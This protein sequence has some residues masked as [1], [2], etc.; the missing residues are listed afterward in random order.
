MG[1]LEFPLNTSTLITRQLKVLGSNGG[2]QE[3]I[4]N[5]LELISKG[6]LTID[7]QL[8]DFDEVPEKIDV[9]R[10]RSVERRFVMETKEKDY[11]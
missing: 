7:I 5:V 6:N 1:A 10:E 3:D 4:A 11:Q 2:T 8:I 9:L